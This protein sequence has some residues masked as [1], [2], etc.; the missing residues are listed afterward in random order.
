MAI[1][2]VGLREQALRYVWISIC[3]VETAGMGEKFWSYSSSLLLFSDQCGMCHHASSTVALRH[4][5]TG[6]T[7]EQHNIQA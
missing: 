3:T 5:R 7:Y 2:Y 6:V 1:V 4:G